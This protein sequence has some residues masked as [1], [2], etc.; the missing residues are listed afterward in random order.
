MSLKPT[1]IPPVPPDKV[2]ATRAVSSGIG[3]IGLGARD[4][5]NLQSTKKVSINPK[6]LVFLESYA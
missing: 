3:R 4:I 6:I 5:R 1:P 2:H